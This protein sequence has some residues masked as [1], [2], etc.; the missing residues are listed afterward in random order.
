MPR[1]ILSSVAAL[2]QACSRFSLVSTLSSAPEVTVAGFSGFTS[3]TGFVS[4]DEV[5][6]AAIQYGSGLDDMIILVEI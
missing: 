2:R 4:G 6:S 5:S 3:G 1:D